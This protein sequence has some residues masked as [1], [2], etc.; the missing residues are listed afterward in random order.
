VPDQEWGVFNWFPMYETGLLSGDA[1]GKSTVLLHLAVAHVLGR[2]W[3]G[4]LPEKGAARR[5]S[6]VHWSERRR[7]GCHLLKKPKSMTPRRHG[8]RTAS[9]G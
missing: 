4:A 5:N 9:N 1:A 8:R 3:L 6:S 7:N 2:D